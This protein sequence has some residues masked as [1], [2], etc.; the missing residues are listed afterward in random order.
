MLAAPLPIMALATLLIKL[1]SPGPVLYRQERVGQGGRSFTILKFRSMCADAEKETASRAGLD[2]TTAASH[3][4]AASSGV[5]ASTNS[6][7]YSMYSS[8]K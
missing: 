4:S 6:R 1:E 2:R 7:R 3:W 5:P 8:A